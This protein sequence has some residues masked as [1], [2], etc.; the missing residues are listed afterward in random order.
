LEIYSRL[1]RQFILETI[2]RI[3]DREQVTMKITKSLL[4]QIIKE[5][6]SKVLDG[7]P[8]NAPDAASF[9]AW[10]TRAAEVHHHRNITE[11]ASRG[12]PS[13]I[14]EMID[15]Y[16]EDDGNSPG[17]G[18]YDMMSAQA[19]YQIT[20]DP[21]LEYGGGPGV[22]PDYLN[23]IDHILSALEISNDSRYEEYERELANED[24]E[25]T[26]AV[27]AAADAAVQELMV[28]GTY[29]DIKAHIEDEM[30]GVD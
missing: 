11:E 10:L 18:L 2:Q 24:S 3:N 29:D 25:L 14:K 7:T 20:E 26:Q 4:K 27:K 8:N 28:D 6:I 16:I 21:R 17:G 12:L 13:D 5:E 23:V 30:S 1:L 19:V 22:Y 9:R 15:I